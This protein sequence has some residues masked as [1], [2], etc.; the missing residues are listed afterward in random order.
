MLPRAVWL[1]ELGYSV[2]LIDFQAHG[3]STGA[4]ITCGLKESQDA[5]AALTFLKTRRPNEKVAAI[6]VSLGGAAT[7]LGE[8]PLAVDAV[9]LESVYTTID[10]AIENRL[11]MRIG[12]LSPMVAPLLVWQSELFA[13][14]STQQLRPIERIHEVRCPVFVIHG[15]EDKHTTLDEAQRLFEQACEP[16]EFWPVNEAAHVDLFD[17]SPSEY[18]W[19][20]GEFLERHLGTH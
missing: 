5:I 13:G 3:E 18:R 12:F 10:A 19:R 4:R 2:L 20:V 15:T 7:L 11:R 6:G 16:K 1:N 17:F 14:V 9:I 8:K